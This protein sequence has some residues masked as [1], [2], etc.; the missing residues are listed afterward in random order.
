[1]QVYRGM[2]IGTAKA[3]AEQRR[4]VPHHMLDLVD[5]EDEFSVAEFQTA[6]RAILG[7]V[8]RVVIVGGSG[9]H[10]RAVVDPMTFPP[11]DPELRSELESLDLEAAVAAL[12][13]ADPDA[14]AH[15]DI[16][17][18]RRVV[19]ALEIHRL[20]GATPS[21]RSVTEEAAALRS[22]RAEYRFAAVALDPGPLL[23][24]RVEKRLDIMIEGGL[25]DEVAGLAPRLGR[26]A[27]QAVGYKELLPVVRGDRPIEEATNSAVR[28]TLRL[29]KHQRT[30]FRRDPRIVWVPWSDDPDD[31]YRTVRSALEEAHE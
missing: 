22:Y 18:P 16:A 3:T 26:T 6:A 2:N 15:V 7:Q 25:L 29:A 9:L 30:Y 28:A 31:R 12:L 27:R 4:R 23:A 11:S 20:T 24:G 19:R 13:A 8:D 10:F 14:A 17:N 5:P 1:M 21:A